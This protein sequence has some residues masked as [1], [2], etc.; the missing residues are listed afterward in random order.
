MKGALA[1]SLLFAVL[2]GVLLHREPSPGTERPQLII[3]PYVGLSLLP[4][5]LWLVTRLWSLRH[6][7]PWIMKPFLLLLIIAGF[8]FGI[9]HCFVTVLYGNANNDAWSDSW[10]VDVIAPPDYFKWANL[11]NFKVA[12]DPALWLPSIQGPHLPTSLSQCGPRMFVRFMAHRISPKSR[13]SKLLDIDGLMFIG[14][15]V[16]STGI[17]FRQTRPKLFT[18]V[19]IGNDVIFNQ[20]VVPPLWVDRHNGFVTFNNVLD[21]ARSQWNISTS[22]FNNGYDRNADIRMHGTGKFFD[23]KKFVMDQYSCMVESSWLEKV[24]NKR[25]CFYKMMEAASV[26]ELEGTLKWPTFSGELRF[27]SGSLDDCSK[28]YV[29]AIYAHDLHWTRD[30]YS[31]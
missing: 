28:P 13:V 18:D 20:L 29:R 21:D 6:S 3:L 10:M 27:P 11:E 23:N 19:A 4:L 1:V 9:G 22:T 30:T 26:E 17:A 5:Y 15:W 24:I 31:C 8:A 16:M 2:L 14:S 7:L 25:W 12:D